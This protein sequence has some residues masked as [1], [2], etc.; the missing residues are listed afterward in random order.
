MS[1][2][3]NKKPTVAIIIFL[4]LG[5][6]CFVYPGHWTL[7]L[8][9]AAIMGPFMS[10]RMGFPE[11]F[12]ALFISVS[13]MLPLTYKSSALRTASFGLGI[14]IWLYLGY[15]TGTFLYA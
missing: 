3:K 12:I 7:P 6:M 9:L 14:T 5:V 1:E 11:G 15:A 13:L 4:L 2:V 8:L 10:V